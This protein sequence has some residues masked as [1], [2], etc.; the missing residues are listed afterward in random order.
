MAYTTKATARGGRN[1]RAVGG[2]ALV[3]AQP[4]EMSG[5]REDHKQRVT[6]TLV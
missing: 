3:M 6:L 1:G 5:S 4:N 2:F